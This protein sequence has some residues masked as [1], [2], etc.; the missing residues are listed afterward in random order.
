MENLMFLPVTIILISQKCS[1]F[2]FLAVFSNSKPLE[3][4]LYSFI[5]FILESEA[6]W[7]TPETPW[8]RSHVSWHISVAQCSQKWM[9]IQSPPLLNSH[10]SPGAQGLGQIQLEEQLSWWM[11][12]SSVKGLG[13][14]LLL[15][16]QEVRLCAG[17]DLL[18][19]QAPAAWNNS[20]PEEPLTHASNRTIMVSWLQSCPFEM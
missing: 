18:P 14:G 3:Q 19:E 4:A 20:F 13:A 5:L 6:P 15:H 9:Q 8:R 2:S 10:P 7:Q 16:P 11:D 1:H 17:P 12:G